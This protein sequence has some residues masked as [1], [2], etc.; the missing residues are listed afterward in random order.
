MAGPD[1]P[2]YFENV[3]RGFGAEAHFRLC[4]QRQPGCWASREK[5]NTEN[6]HPHGDPQTHTHTAGQC[7]SQLH[8]FSARCPPLATQLYTELTGLFVSL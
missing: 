5:P 1:V 3:F 6:K 8:I 2:A 7:V 4:H